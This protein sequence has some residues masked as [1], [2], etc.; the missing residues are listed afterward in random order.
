MRKYS[1]F[2]DRRVWDLWRTRA[3]KRFEG[4]SNFAFWIFGI[5]SSKWPANGQQMAS[6][7]PARAPLSIPFHL[8]TVRGPMSLSRRLKIRRMWGESVY[9]RLRPYSTPRSQSTE[10]LRMESSAGEICDVAS[11]TNYSVTHTVQYHSKVSMRVP[12]TG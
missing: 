12:R 1:M 5:S 7:W 3:Q 9:M 11:S 6:K 2:V 10:V 4:A 8:R